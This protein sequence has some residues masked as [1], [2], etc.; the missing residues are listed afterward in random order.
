MNVIKLR[1]AALAVAIT[2][3]FTGHASAAP[4]SRASLESLFQLTHADTM[5]DGVYA[6]MQKSMSQ[7]F[8]QDASQ[9][10]V[11]PSRQRIAAKAMD[12]MMALLRSQYNWKVMEPDMI[13]AYQKTFTEEEVTAMINFYAT[14]AGQ[15]AITKMPQLMQS[16]MAGSQ[17]RLQ[18][19]L[20][21]MRAVAEKAQ[22]DAAAA[23][24]E[25]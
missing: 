7:M 25:H 24:A 3:A 20:P 13:D 17:A 1:S 4:A 8:A 21:Q 22:A 16:V 19:L 10:A 11:S 6:T 5:V 23:D 14:P 15:A 9:R 18:A 12:D 2:L